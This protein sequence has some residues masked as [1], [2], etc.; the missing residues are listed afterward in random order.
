MSARRKKIVAVRDE[1]VGRLKEMGIKYTVLLADPG[2]DQRAIIGAVDFHR[3]WLA[4]YING[5]CRTEEELQQLC[6]W[7][8]EVREANAT[9]NAK[10]S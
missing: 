10:I 8:R 5:L 4:E 9:D 7:V 6:G 3:P 1:F 2:E